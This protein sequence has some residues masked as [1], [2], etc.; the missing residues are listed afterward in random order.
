ME[1]VAL[2]LC[3]VVLCVEEFTGDLSLQFVGLV[4]VL[5]QSS[6]PVHS[7]LAQ[8]PSVESVWAHPQ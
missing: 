6:L 3:K 8:P 1:P 5:G 4:S 7:A 2:D